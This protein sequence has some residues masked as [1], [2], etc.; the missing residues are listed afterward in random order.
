[1]IQTGLANKM[2]EGLHP[3]FATIVNVKV[4][5]ELSAIGMLQSDEA[6]RAA[7]L[8][9]QMRRNARRL[10]RAVQV[11]A[12]R[13]GRTTPIAEFV[14]DLD[15]GVSWAIRLAR[16]PDAH[17]LRLS[18]NVSLALLAWLAVRGMGGPPD[19]PD[20]NRRC[21]QRMREWQLDT[22]VA[23]AFREIGRND[24][25]AEQATEGVAA[26]QELPMW[27]PNG[28]TADASAVIGSWLT[29]DGV[30][31]ALDVRR[32]GRVEHFNAEAYAEMV[33][34]T[35]WIASVRLA[36]Y[37]QAYLRTSEPMVDW[38]ATLSRDL[39]RAGAAAD[40]RVDSLIAW[41]QSG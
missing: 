20:R 8:S 11:M 27:R 29:D 17:F 4:A 15:A 13:Q 7:V 26:I 41:K 5:Y 9:H 3:P 35:T 24:G 21:R 10:A 18:P 16:D 33:V 12:G 32:H 14:A 22:I 38:V 2:V 30:R 34:W 6:G 40:G 36:E 31:R 23:M 28:D 37:P 1:M 39:Q 19:V 25:A